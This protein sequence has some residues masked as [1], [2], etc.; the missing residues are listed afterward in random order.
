VL[1]QYP[2]AEFFSCSVVS[3]REISHILS[4]HIIIELLEKHPWKVRW[5]GLCSVV[6]GLFFFIKQSIA[7]VPKHNKRSLWY[8]I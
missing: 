7:A 3:W 4:L 1:L 6:A 2:H 8:I 5:R